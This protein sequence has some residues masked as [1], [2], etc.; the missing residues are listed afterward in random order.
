MK[1]CNNCGIDVESY[2]AVFRSPELEAVSGT[3]PEWKDGNTCPLCER[4]FLLD[5]EIN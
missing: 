3:A 1:Q 2:D 4:D 5:A